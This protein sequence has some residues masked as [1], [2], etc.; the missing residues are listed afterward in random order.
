MGFAKWVI[1]GSSQFTPVITRG[2]NFSPV[3]INW[4]L[5]T[6]WWDD[7]RPP[8]GRRG[9]CA[10]RAVGKVCR[11]GHREAVATLMQCIRDRLAGVSVVLGLKKTN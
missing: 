11:L 3:V 10:L 4:I 6:P 7:P 1:S 2:E 9:A 5:G 8:V